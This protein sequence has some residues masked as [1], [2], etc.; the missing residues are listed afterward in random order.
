MNF[1]KPKKL[2]IL[3]NNVNFFFE[4]TATRKAGGLNLLAGLWGAK[5]KTRQRFRR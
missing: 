1:L 2:S 4:S 5:A 3:Y